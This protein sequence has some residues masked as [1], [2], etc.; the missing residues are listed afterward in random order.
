[1]YTIFFESKL[2]LVSFIRN[3]LKDN[4]LLRTHVKQFH[5][6]RTDKQNQRKCMTESLVHPLNISIIFKLQSTY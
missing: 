5:K 3:A 4:V 1:M 6:K 2:I